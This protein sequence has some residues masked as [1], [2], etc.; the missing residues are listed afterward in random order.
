VERLPLTLQRRM[1]DWIE[2]AP[3]AGGACTAMVRWIATTGDTGSGCEPWPALA[4]AL[5]GL[6]VRLP[7][8]R[9][10]PHLI[11]SAVGET[12]R[13]WCERHRERPRR[14]GED[15]L[16]VM[17]EYPW[18][19]NLRELEAVVVQTLAAGASDPVR[20]DDLQ[21]DGQ[22][23]SPLGAGEV[24]ELIVGGEPEDLEELAPLEEA[25]APAQ[26]ETAQ[27]E[28]VVDAD[29]EPSPQPSQPPRQRS[30]APGEA[31]SLARLVASL[32][33]EVRNPLASI[34]TFAGLL[35]ERFQDPEFR[36]R[37]AELVSQDVDRIDALVDRLDR[38]SDLQSPKREAVDIAA[39]LE[40]L[41]DER[42][43]T[44]RRRRLLV[45]KELDA[46]RPLVEADREQL[47]FAFDMLLGKSLELVP[48]RGDVYL[49]SRY[50]EAQPPDVASVRVLVRFHDPDTG[51]GSPAHFDVAFAERSLELVIAELVIRAQGGHFALTGGDGKETV[52]VVDLPAQ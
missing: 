4:R 8:L 41:L 46:D 11:A 5:S 13:A 19:G 14:F 37:F 18:P 50:H 40:R 26:V 23:F 28:P 20:S 1:R 2:C 52:I 42:E 3:P 27:P 29:P 22:A 36:G 48:E 51:G 25:E 35:P 9:E 21:Y 30:A 47:G 7:P 10:R 24:G 39:L 12:S 38:L 49:A 45:L 44:I 33:H 34:R 6:S 43:E 15:A 31:A 16:A 32:T 17:E